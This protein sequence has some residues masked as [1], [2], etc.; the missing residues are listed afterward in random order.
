MRG[1]NSSK[2]RRREKRGTRKELRREELIGAETGN[3]KKRWSKNKLSVALAYPNTYYVGMSSLGFQAVY[4]MLNS[5]DDVVCERFF[6]GGEEREAR[7][8]ESNTPL[9]SFDV[10]AF[11][12][13]FELDYPAVLRVIEAAGI[14]LLQKDRKK[15]PLVFIGGICA[16]TNPEPLAMFLDG[17]FLGDAEPLLSPVIDTLLSSRAK[18][19]AYTL[20]QLAEQKGFYVPHLKTD[21]K[22]DIVRA[23]SLSDSPL[24]SPILTPNTEFGEKHLIEVTRGCPYTCPFCVVGN[25]CRPFRKQ[26]LEALKVTASSCLSA[27][28]VKIGFVGVSIADHPEFK[29]IIKIPGKG[30]MAIASIRADLIDK[31]IAVMLRQNGHKTVSIAPEAG[32]TR[33]IK[34]LGKG[35][36]KEDVVNAMHVL[37]DAGIVNFRLY[38]MIGLV[39]ET[40]ED[41][42][43]LAV[44]VKNIML[45]YTE[46]CRKGGRIGTVTLSVNPFVPKPFTPFQWASM[47]SEK[48]LSDRVKILKR[49]LAKTSNLRMNFTSIRESVRQAFLS[50]GGRSVGKFL[51]KLH[52]NGGDWKETERLEDEV[53]NIN[54]V[55]FREK[56][57]EEALPWDFINEPKEELWR[58][59]N[60]YKEAL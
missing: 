21:S 42:L 18:G 49:E 30:G 1:K 5:R 55:V 47:A 60:K 44:F 14:P 11:S 29:Q 59:F 26:S 35:I 50:L 45:I 22:F 19:R 57:F 37:T 52:E 39:G 34:A 40:D 32:S 56:D 20:G 4:G 33:I 48:V 46:Q 54:S 3:I 43:E 13:S 9:A 53:N 24:H 36:E 16:F 58:R 2:N 12:V 10:L 51:I 7:S 6:V 17:V 15:F 38:F 28:P 25:H 8:I 27:N 31:D 41:I 23:A